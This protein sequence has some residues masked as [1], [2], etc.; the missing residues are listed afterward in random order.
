MPPAGLQHAL[1]PPLLA[2]LAAVSSMSLSG[3]R[4]PCPAALQPDSGSGSGSDQYSPA[5]LPPSLPPAASAA[6]CSA[7]E[8]TAQSPPA[9]PSERRRCL[10]AGLP[11][12]GKAAL[13]SAAGA[14][15][16]AAALWSGCQSPDRLLAGKRPP[17]APPC[18]SAALP[19]S[20][21]GL[22]S[23]LRLSVGAGLRA[24]VGRSNMRAAGRQAG[25][26]GGSQHPSAS[27]HRG[28]A[29]ALVSNPASHA[30]ARTRVDLRR[31]AEAAA[32]ED[33]GRRAVAAAPCGPRCARCG[34]ARGGRRHDRRR[35]CR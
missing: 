5:A 15:G 12:E 27:Q 26:S 22:M 23:S 7:A 10:A 32:E 33:I 24:V 29:C 31:K 4:A 34:L 30:A 35:G 17:Q 13:M 16:A 2:G 3:T 28:T 6:A 18:G 9:P 1:L 19:P 20:P 14:G 8:G 25:G 11:T 21:P